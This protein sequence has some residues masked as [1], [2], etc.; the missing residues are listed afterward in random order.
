MTYANASKTNCS[1]LCRYIICILYSTN[2]LD[3]KFRVV[4]LFVTVDVV[5]TSRPNIQTIIH[6]SRAGMLTFHLRNNFICLD[7]MVH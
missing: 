4:A 6:I 5:P 7:S 3:L 2:L 1:F